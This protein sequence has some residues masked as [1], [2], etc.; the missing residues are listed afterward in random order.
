MNEL[1]EISVKAGLVLPDKLDALM[2]ELL[3]GIVV[4]NQDGEVLDPT[5][6]I[7]DLKAVTYENI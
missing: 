7:I 6:T 4:Y 1:E 2:S 3:Y 5:K